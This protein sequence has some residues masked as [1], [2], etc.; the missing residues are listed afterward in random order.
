MSWE[1]LL[2][3]KDSSERKRKLLSMIM[4][5]KLEIEDEKDNTKRLLSKIEKLKKYIE[6]LED[7]LE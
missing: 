7:M 5:T 1:N 4:R 3:D 6:E 2:K